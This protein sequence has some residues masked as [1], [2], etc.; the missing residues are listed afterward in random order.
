MGITIGTRIF[1]W[2]KGQYVGTDQFGNRYYRARSKKHVHP[3]SLRHER[4]WVLY[5]GEVEASKVP[6]DWHAWLH[7]TSD[8]VPPEG[9]RAKQPWQKE[10]LP[11]QTG[12][13]QA[14]RPPGHTLHGGRRDKATG[15]YQAW[16]PE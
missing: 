9:G 16:K 10:H 11:N 3:D 8:E 15:D 12:T 6:A 5:K 1:S 13:D 4:R 2:L 14:Y 7:H